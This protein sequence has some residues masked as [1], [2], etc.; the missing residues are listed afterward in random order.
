MKSTIPWKRIDV[1]LFG[2]LIL[3]LMLYQIQHLVPHFA[4]LHVREVLYL[5]LYFR[6]L[7]FYRINLTLPLLVMLMLLA[8]ACLVA[9]HTYY[10]AGI[11]VAVPAFSRF[12]HLA[13]VAPLAAVLLEK[14]Q[15][16][17]MMLYLWVVVVIF[18]IMTIIYQ[19]LGGEM[20]WLVQKYIA[21]RGDL[22]RHKSLLGEPNVGGMSAALLYIL[23]SMIVRRV[24]I[25][26]LLLFASSFLVVV[27]I[28]KAAFIGF[29][30]ANLV[31]LASDYKIARKV[32]SVFP[33][34]RIIFQTLAV[35]GWFL[36]MALHPLLYRYLE[37]NFNSFIGKQLAVPGAIEDFSD[38]FIFFRFGG[39]VG[40]RDYLELLFGQSFTRAG[41]VALDLKIPNAVG[42]HNM[43]LEVFL[44]GGLILLAAF[45][46]VQ[47]LTIKNLILNKNSNFKFNTILLPNFVLISIFMTVYPNFYE[48][49]T[50]TLFWLI[51]G[52]TC[53]SLSNVTA[54][55]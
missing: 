24:A 30:F 34:R 53:S 20:A 29:I 39:G 9:I 12:V 13:L 52:V 41:S 48:P 25:R 37:V 55:N 7:F 3:C 46:A 47:Y 14:D 21:I 23:A 35:L 42:P 22:L 38:R 40:F 43:Y 27:S 54:R 1:F 44:V 6:V 8:G 16:I 4:K 2:F 36:L 19:M 50:G 15:D 32:G 45:I 17:L 49:I 5:Y 31:I 10:L 18:G 26:Y 28:S 51:V 11:V 33:S